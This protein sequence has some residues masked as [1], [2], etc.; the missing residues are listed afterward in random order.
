MQL[1][2][3]ITIGLL[4]ATFTFVVLCYFK[5]S[6]TKKV[7]KVI[8]KIESK[9][10]GLKGAIFLP[11]D[12]AEEARQEHIADNKKKGIDTPMSELR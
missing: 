6:V 10:S 1:F 7:E 3:G 5:I 12:D 4:I 8:R 9:G 11:P 2:F